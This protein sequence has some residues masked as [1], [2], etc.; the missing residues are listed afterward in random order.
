MNVQYSI[1]DWGIFMGQSPLF[2]IKMTSVGAGSKLDLLRNL[3]A[4]H[5]DL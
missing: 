3:L 5:P 1:N 4:N 2:V